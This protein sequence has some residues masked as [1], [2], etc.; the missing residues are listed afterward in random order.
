[1]ATRPFTAPNEL[2]PEEEQKYEQELAEQRRDGPSAAAHDLYAELKTC[3]E[4]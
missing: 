1:M 3:F 2:S 4:Q